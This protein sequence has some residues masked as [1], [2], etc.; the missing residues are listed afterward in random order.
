MAEDKDRPIHSLAEYEAALEVVPL[1]SR[2]V[3]LMV[4][5]DDLSYREIADRL[6][7]GAD[8]VQACLADA[9]L[10]MLNVLDGRPPR[11]WPTP[12]I[13]AAENALRARYRE[14]C[15][16]RLRRLGLAEPIRWDQYDDDEAAV[17]EGVLQT[18]PSKVREAAAL[19]QYEH[20]SQR[21]IA[22]R[23]GVWRWSVAIHLMRAR[24]CLAKR[25]MLFEQ[26]LYREASG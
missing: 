19:Y 20:L 15:A 12:L 23:M 22:A 13:E 26:W 17:D 24:R 1:L 21:Q 6:S 5:V 8:A 16:A 3:F 10:I 4:C 7:I 2:L 9:L 14:Y 11:R 18:M 25:P